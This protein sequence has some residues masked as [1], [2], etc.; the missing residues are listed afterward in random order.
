MAAE[1]IKRSPLQVR[2]SNKRILNVEKH[3]GIAISGR[4]SDGMV[5]VERARKEAESYKNNFGIPISGQI[6]TERI[7]N[8][9]HAYTLYGYF[10]PL[11]V[12]ILVAS[13]DRGKNFLFKI[14]NTG[15][16]KG[17][18]GV[19][20]GKGN[21]TAKTYLEKADRTKSCQDNMKN[22]ALA[23]AAAHE[24]FKEKTYEF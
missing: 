24:E 21:Q 9:M 11:G 19:T 17:Y 2:D 20:A 4:L 7:A 13:R 22:V 6:L 3:I 18:F 1:N 12:E 8:F 10:R 5:V 23:I 16:F 15:N 14:E